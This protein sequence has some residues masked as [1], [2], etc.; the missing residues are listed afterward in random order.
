VDMINYIEEIIKEFDG[1][2]EYTHPADDQLFVNGDTKGTSKDPK[3]FS[4]V[5]LLSCYSFAKVGDLTLPCR[6]ITCVQ[7]EESKRFG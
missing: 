2:K 1:V 3:K 4:T 5:S 7:S 6:S